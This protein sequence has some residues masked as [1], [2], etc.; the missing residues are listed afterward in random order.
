MKTIHHSTNY[1][2]YTIGNGTLIVESTYETG[3]DHLRKWSKGTAQ[4]KNTHPQFAEYVE[5]FSTATDNTEADA[6]CKAI[7]A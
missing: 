7:L 4:V 6:L 1:A 5:A 3:D 2:A